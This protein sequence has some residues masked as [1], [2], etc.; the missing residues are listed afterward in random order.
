MDTARILVSQKSSI[1][2]NT[3]KLQKKDHTLFRVLFDK[4]G[5]IEP[6][7]ILVEGDEQQKG[8]ITFSLN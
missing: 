5:M 4:F 8:K 6:C 7:N 2:F 1:T 3:N